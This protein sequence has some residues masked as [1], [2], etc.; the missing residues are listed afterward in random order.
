MSY[1][2]YSSSVC[3]FFPKLRTLTSRFDHIMVAIEESK[4]LDALTIQELINFS[5]HMNR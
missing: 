1:I 5:K 3:E 4:D 2:A